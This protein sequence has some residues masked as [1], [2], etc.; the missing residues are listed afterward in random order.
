M[1]QAL[2]SPTARAAAAQVDEVQGQLRQAG[3][4]LNPR[5]FLQSEDLRPWAG[6]YDFPT[7]TEHYGYL[8]Q[9][10]EIDGKRRK[11]T[12][13]A[14]ARLMQARATEQQTNQAIAGRTAAAYWG[15]AVLARSV[16]VLRAEMG[17]V[18]EM[19]RYNK[20]RLD[21][22]AMRGVDLLRMQMERDRMAIDLRSMEREA[23]QARLELFRQMGQRP[24]AEVEL[25]DKVD[26]VI[27][28]PPVP[29][30]TVLAQRPDV[31]AARDALTA[32]EADVTLQRALGVPD[33]DLL[34]G[35]KRNGANNTLYGGL[36]LNLP[37]RNR[38]Q[39]EIERAQ[40]S[41]RI[42]RENLAELELQV[43]AEVAESEL[44]YQ[45]EREVVE[46]LL[47]DMRQRAKENLRLVTEAYR[48]GGVD[49]LRYLDAE[50]TEFVVE[51]NALR[52]MAE[53][54]QAAVRLQL[55]YGEQ[56]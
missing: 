36:Q 53:M 54:Q 47:P 35:Y 19:V 42:A 48:I 30:E 15:A 23:E 46:T 38:N 49:L 28:P 34:G 29:V 7:Q 37:F 33:L 1:R 14:S 45:R 18:D 12:S 17:A 6:N 44:N 26:Q 16:T 55:S 25:T 31:L 40:A 22:G 56:P 39:G 27:P 24:P 32:A 21:A 41:V 10:F 52:M 9:T 11:R 4:G 3:L 51:V 50:R 13:V 2:A 8:S 43:R 5:L 20:E